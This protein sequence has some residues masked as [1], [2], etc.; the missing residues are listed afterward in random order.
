MSEPSLVHLDLAG[1]RSALAWAAT[2]GWNPGLHDAEPFFVADP[3]GYLGLEVDGRIAVVASVVRWSDRYAFGGLFIAAPDVRGE[4]LGFA[5]MQAALAFAGDRTIGLDAVLEQEPLY[6]RNGAVA[7]STTTRWRWERSLDP[8][9]ETD[10]A[11]G[12]GAD[13]TVDARTLA[14]ADLVVFERDCVAGDR[15]AFLTAW[16]AAPDS[17]ARAVVTDGALRAWGLRRPCVEG[18]RIGPLFATDAD[19]AEAVW[20]SMTAGVDGPVFLDAPDPN[21]IARTLTARHGMTPG[22]TTRRMYFGPDPG[23]DLD[24]VVGV[25]TLELG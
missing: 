13:A 11:S 3:G 21:T 19:A 10:D 1:L 4:G 8:C 9:P 25:T 17:V 22:F 7:S 23:L 2:E 12:T 18:H 14:I 20:A 5:M 6:A 16:L 24:R 15:T